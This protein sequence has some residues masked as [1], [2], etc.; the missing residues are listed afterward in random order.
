MLW[1]ILFS[2]VGAAVGRVLAGRDELAG[3]S[4]ATLA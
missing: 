3:E 4:K 1:A 2:P